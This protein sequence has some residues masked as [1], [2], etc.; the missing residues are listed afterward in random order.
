MVLVALRRAV[1][2]FPLYLVEGVGPVRDGRRRWRC[3][4]GRLVRSL[5]VGALFEL[6]VLG[7]RA[8]ELEEV[9]RFAWAG[10]ILFWLVDGHWL[11]RPGLLGLLFLLGSHG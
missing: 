8:L 6:R 10:W 7:A 3:G 2:I 11:R 5:Q 4:G 9:R 1:L